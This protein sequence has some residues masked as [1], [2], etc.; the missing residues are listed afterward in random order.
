MLPGGFDRGGRGRGLLR[1]NDSGRGGEPSSR[2]RVHE[3][4]TEDAGD[5]AVELRPA[6]VGQRVPLD[7]EDHKIF[8][9]NEVIQH[10][11]RGQAPPVSAGARERQA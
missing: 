4:P 6:L 10:F 9:R 11:L 7:G 3:L 8:E 1:G 2:D 5:R